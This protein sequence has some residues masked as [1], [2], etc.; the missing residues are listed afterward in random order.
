MAKYT[1]SDI[2]TRMVD[3]ENKFRE[4]KAALV[5]GVA[6]QTGITVVRMMNVLKDTGRSGV[7]RL[8]SVVHRPG[9]QRNLLSWTTYRM[10]PVLGL[11]GRRNACQGRASPCCK[12]FMT[13]STIPTKMRREFAF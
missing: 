9:I 4:L 11:R 3:Y 1:L 6:V 10:R 2:D 8:R 12:K 5:E 13:F 7:L